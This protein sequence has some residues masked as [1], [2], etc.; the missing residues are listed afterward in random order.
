[1]KKSIALMLGLLAGTA[2]FANTTE[3]PIA[4]TPQTKLVIAN[5][6]KLRL[7]VNAFPTSA[8]VA[9]KDAAGHVLF[10]EKYTLTKG[11]NRVF[12][13]SELEKGTYYL[14]VVTGNETQTKTFVVQD[15][16]TQKIV[17][18]QS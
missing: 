10:T 2:S 3:E 14:E 8:R 16:P 7:Y 18:L 17:T 4:Q 13:I 11:L 15:V 9:L 12:N 6:Q 1:M 5:N